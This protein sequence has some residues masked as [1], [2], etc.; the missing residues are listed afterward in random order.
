MQSVRTEGKADHFELS[1][2][3]YVFAS[4]RSEFC[5]QNSVS[6]LNVFLAQWGRSTAFDEVK[7]TRL[8]QLELGEDSNAICA[9]IQYIADEKLLIKLGP[10]AACRVKFQKQQLRNIERKMKDT[11]T[12][13]D[14]R[15]RS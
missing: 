5:G 8:P 9:W 3:W 6:C 12:K 15:R 1:N 14:K 2:T 11:R 10:L 7:N 4:N 13:K